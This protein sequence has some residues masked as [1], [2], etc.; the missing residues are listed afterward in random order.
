MSR[1]RSY[2]IFLLAL[3]LAPY[4]FIQAQPA[5]IDSIAKPVFSPP[6]SA[7]DSGYTPFKVNRIIITGNK[8]TKDKVIL[9]EL[10][11]QKGEEYQLPELVKKFENA[12]TYLMN[13][14]LFV[15]VVVAL[16][17]FNGYDV[18]I[19]VDVKERWYLFPI[20][21][22]KPI[23][24][25]LNQWL[26]EK[27]AS[28]TRVNYGI[29]LA[30]NNVSGR[31]DKLRV[32]LTNGYTK[33]VSMSYDRPYIDKKMKWGLSLS[34]A[35]GKN[36]EVNY[37]TINNKQVFIKDENNFIRNYF[38]TAVELYYRRAIKTRH[39]FGIAYTSE[40]LEDTVLTK[41]PKYFNSE[42]N[43][44]SFPDIYYNLNLQ[45]VNFIPYPLRGYTADIGITKRGFNSP[46]SLW[47]LTLRGAAYRQLS[48]KYFFSLK[49][50]GAVKLPF[51][52][53]PFINQRL[54]GYG[55]IGMQGYEYYVIDGVAGGYIKTTLSKEI[56]KFSIRL[57]SKKKEE[58]ESFSRVPFTVYAK[59]FGNTGYVY[60]PAQGNNFL[61]NKMLYS[62]GI[63]LDIVTFYDFIFRLEWSFNAQGQNGLFLHQ[64]TQY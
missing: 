41:N 59:I 37:N 38:R 35:T 4:I 56:L 5:S 25:N 26:V 6:V 2:N 9:R 13:T 20:P 18:D 40:L 46:V 7:I 43:R 28:L 11:F 44:I 62:G 14:A 49:A 42:L 45:D 52:Q 57:P 61:A 33:E 19:L 15:D 32:Y 30:Y 23:D 54:L 36:H 29:K 22:F 8:K 53:Q 17:S 47:Q 39:R 34:V 50:A 3:L 64:K 48:L 27:K 60:N 55:D 12:R 21:Y 51:D 58:H 16:K 10:P 1:K 24:R 31:N 63:G